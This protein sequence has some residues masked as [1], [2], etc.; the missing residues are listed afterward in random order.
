[1]LNDAWL[2]FFSQEVQGAG[3]SLSGK[4]NALFLRYMH[5][6][7][8]WNRS[9]NLTRIIEPKAIATK[10][11]LDSI[12]ITRHINIARK[13]IADVGSGGGF[14]GIPLAI[15]E[16]DCRL[17]LIESVRKKT[18]F[19]K[20][21][22]RTLKLKNVQVY[23]G[24]AQDFPEPGTFDLALSRAFSSLPQFAD[25]ALKLIKPQGCIVCMKGPLP[26]D[27]IDALKKGLKHTLELESHTYCLPR[28]G[29]SRSLV[30]LRP[31][32]T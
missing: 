10:H 15:L 9:T 1:M 27:E 5:E 4:Q 19:L 6:L 13:K 7:I 22:V 2:S 24:R 28:Q 20:H 3:L 12:L 8:E 26:L 23:N 17:V 25:I 21:I 16:P 18:S 14:P 29:G 32:S 31:C 11:F 30:L